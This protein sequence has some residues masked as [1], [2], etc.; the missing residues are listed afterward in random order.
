MAL[1]ATQKTNLFFLCLIIFCS[2]AFQ[3]NANGSG[4]FLVD[5]VLTVGKYDERLPL[6]CIA[7]QTVLAKNLGHFPQWIG[8]LQVAKECEYNML[9]FTP[10][11]ELGLS[12]SAYCLKDQ[13]LLNP[14]FTPDGTKKFDFADVKNLVDFM[15]KEWDVLSITDLVFNHTANESPW[16]QEHPECAYNVV[17]SPHLKPAYLLD[18]II[19]HFSL[20]IGEGKWRDKGIPADISSED[21]LNVI[22]LVVL[23]NQISNHSALSL[24]TALSW[25]V[26]G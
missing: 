8:R 3:V 6:D 17:N 14:V 20:E 4:Y 13:L 26:G 24:C 25:S 22:T 9:H 16:I 1:M 11:Q 5:P 15:R 7:C 18:R 10:V 2:S 19:W 23:M 12:N 21:H